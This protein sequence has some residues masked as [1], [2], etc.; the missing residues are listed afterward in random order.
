MGA[1]AVVAALSAAVQ[2]ASPAELER[3]LRTWDK[4]SLE[5]LAMSC[6]QSAE[7]ETKEAALFEQAG[8]TLVGVDGNLLEEQPTDKMASVIEVKDFVAKAKKIPWP[9]VQLVQDER[10]LGDGL[11]EAE[12]KVPTGQVQFV[13]LD[14]P[15]HTST[16]NSQQGVCASHVQVDLAGKMYGERLEMADLRLAALS[17]CKRLEELNLSYNGLDDDA[18]AVVVYAMKSM[19]QLI[20]LRL[21]DNQIEDAGLKNILGAVPKSLKVLVL[22]SNKITDAG[23]GMIGDALAHMPNIQQIELGDNYI[24]PDA[25]KTLKEK[26]KALPELTIKSGL[27]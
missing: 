10:P 15:P 20:E 27:I 23:A 25:H 16:V 11:F 6:K 8:I 4:A 5:K 12:D 3:E 7:A 2:T 17:R 22:S 9:W 24:T 18:V 14:R 13:I 1:G 19:P 26:A 21:Q